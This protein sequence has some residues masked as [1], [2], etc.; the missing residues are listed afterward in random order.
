MPGDAGN[1]VALISMEGNKKFMYMSV[2]RAVF[3]DWKCFLASSWSKTPIFRAECVKK[4]HNCD[5]FSSNLKYSS[6]EIISTFIV[7]TGSWIS[8]HLGDSLFTEE[9]KSIWCYMFSLIMSSWLKQSRTHTFHRNWFDQSLLWYTEQA[10]KK[11]WTVDKV[12]VRGV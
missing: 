4:N 11:L 7:Y 3:Q 10:T 9:W 12:T 2:N 8:H 1:E 5:F 6:L